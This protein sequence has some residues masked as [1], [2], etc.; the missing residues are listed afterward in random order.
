MRCES[1]WG[2]R[3]AP[4][5]VHLGACREGDDP[6]GKGGKEG[7]RI[8]KKNHEVDAPVAN[9]YLKNNLDMGFFFLLAKLS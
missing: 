8:K 9:K 5:H 6:G 2:S 4:A 7:E 3:P 1:C